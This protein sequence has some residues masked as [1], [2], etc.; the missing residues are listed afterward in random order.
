MIYN[1]STQG[2]S[3]TIEY[4]DLPMM[5]WLT[6]VLET[7]LLNASDNKSYFE[8]YIKLMLEARRRIIKCDVTKASD[9][10]NFSSQS[11]LF[12][13]DEG[14]MILKDFTDSLVR[15]SKFK[16]LFQSISATRQA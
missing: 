3:G 10:K 1:I 2:F 14:L 5:N 9:G 4:N 8:S 11:E 7:G 12:D 16:K 15:L 13:S 6:S